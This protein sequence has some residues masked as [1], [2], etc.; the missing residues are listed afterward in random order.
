[1]HV[2]ERRKNLEDLEEIQNEKK[3]LLLKKFKFTNVNIKKKKSIK[4]EIFLN[5]RYKVNVFKAIVSCR[6]NQI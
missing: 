3:H 6:I 5:K 2:F 1:M 4:C